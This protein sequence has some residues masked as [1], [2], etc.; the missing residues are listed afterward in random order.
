MFQGIDGINTMLTETAKDGKEIYVIN[1]A[2]SFNTLTDERLLQRSYKK[3][4]E[5]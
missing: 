5:C 4:K 3:R 2:H 1:D